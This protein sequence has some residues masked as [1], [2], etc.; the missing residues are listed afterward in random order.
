MSDRI[1]GEATS[2]RSRRRRKSNPVREFLKIMI[3]GLVGLALGNAIL[4]WGLKVDLF[5]MAKHLPAFM[6]P[7]QLM[8]KDEPMTGIID[9][10]HRLAAGSV[11]RGTET[12]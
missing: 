2:P 7:E 4:F 5:H 3:G 8:P 9:R 10:G 6:V 1:G 11:C 12:A